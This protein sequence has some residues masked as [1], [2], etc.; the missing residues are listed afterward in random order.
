M[1]FNSEKNKNL[2]EFIKKHH[3]LEV[4]LYEENHYK[5]EPMKIKKSIETGI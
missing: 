5:E 3:H 1:S 2:Q 4:S